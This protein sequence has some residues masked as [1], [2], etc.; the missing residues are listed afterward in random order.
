MTVAPPRST[1]PTNAD[2]EQLRL[3]AMLWFVYGGL[4]GLICVMGLAMVVGGLA[5]ETLGTAA[6]ATQA[7]LGGDWQGNLVGMGC[8]GTFLLL[9][10]S[11]FALFGAAVAALRLLTGF[12]LLHHRHRVFCLVVAAVSLLAVPLGAVIGIATLIVILQPWA[13]EL[14]ADGGG[15]GGGGGGAPRVE[16]PA[17]GL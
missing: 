16:R 2:L 3:L 5:M 4:A 10:G 1:H 12:A 6:M 8:G 11:F 14:F 9:V 7:P 15:S 13:E 17:A